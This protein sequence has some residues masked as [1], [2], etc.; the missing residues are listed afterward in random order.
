VRH[1]NG[2]VTCSH[3]SRATLEKDP[4]NALLSLEAEPLSLCWYLTT[5]VLKKVF[6]VSVNECMEQG[7]FYKRTETNVAGR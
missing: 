2:I 4:W 5:S 3:L 7:N 1:V 6:M